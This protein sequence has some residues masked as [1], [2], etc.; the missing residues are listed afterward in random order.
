MALSRKLALERDMD[1]PQGSYV[2]IGGG[3]GGGDDVHY[4]TT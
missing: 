4:A 1:L 2:L 3:G